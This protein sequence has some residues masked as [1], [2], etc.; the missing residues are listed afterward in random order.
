M[1]ERAQGLL[2]QQAA[3]FRGETVD[4]WP[5]RVK[6][7]AAVGRAS[8]RRDLAAIGGREGTYL[9]QGLQACAARAVA[10]Y[11]SRFASLDLGSG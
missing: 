5:G 11:G 2:L 9:K 6:G 10:L 8:L 3:A 7:A 1:A 4:Y